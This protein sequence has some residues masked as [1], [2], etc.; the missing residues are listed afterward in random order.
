MRSSFFEF[1]VAITGTSTS[2]ANLEIISHNT[3]NAAIKGYSRQVPM[4][5]ANEPLALNTG[6]GMVGTGAHVFDVLQMRDIFLDN[7]YWAQKCVLGEYSGKKSHLELIE[8]VFNEM[9]E[10]S[11]ISSAITDFFAKASDLS[12]TANDPTYRTNLIQSAG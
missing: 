7:K 11:G 6:K 5:Q 9:G 3:A 12:T 2:R 10:G 8:S 4:Q 1:H